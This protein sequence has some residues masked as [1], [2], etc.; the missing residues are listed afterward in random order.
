M[1]RVRKTAAGTPAQPIQAFSGQQYGRGAE[2]ERMQQAMP[3]PNEPTVA[4][5]APAT[6]QVN[7]QTQRQ[8]MDLAQLRETL[9]GVGG[10]LNQPDERPDVPF[11]QL[12]DDPQSLMNLNVMKSVNKTGEVMRELSR[13]TGDPTFADLAAKAGF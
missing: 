7:E 12:L 5:T 1:P 4:E 10:I 11:T 13:R 8:P 6:S 3:T 2:Q 9:A